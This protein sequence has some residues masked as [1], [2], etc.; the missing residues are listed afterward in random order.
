MI[1]PDHPFSELSLSSRS[2]KS[3]SRVLAAMATCTYEWLTRASYVYHISCCKPGTFGVGIHP[4]T[5]NL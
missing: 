1:T 3:L 5:I 2:D 4:D